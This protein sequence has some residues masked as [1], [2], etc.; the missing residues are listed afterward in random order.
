M[1]TFFLHLPL[2]QSVFRIHNIQRCNYIMLS[3]L[4]INM[5]HILLRCTTNTRLVSMY[6]KTWC[7]RKGYK[8]IKINFN[9]SIV[10]L[11]GCRLLKPDRN[12][13]NNNQSFVQLCM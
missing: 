11:D 3:Y 5:D 1:F 13:N 7:S 12:F 8:L 4:I 10:Y 9:N 2:N 6:T